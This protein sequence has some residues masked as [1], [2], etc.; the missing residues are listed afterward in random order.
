MIE[1]Y[2][3]AQELTG[4]MIIITNCVHLPGIEE[5]SIKPITGV[6]SDRAREA[7]TRAELRKRRVGGKTIVPR[8]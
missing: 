5:F 4:G 8:R 3:E 7:N 2:A 1:S 6:R